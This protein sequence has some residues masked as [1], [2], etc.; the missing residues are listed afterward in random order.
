MRLRLSDRGDSKSAGDTAAHMV[1]GANSS[2]AALSEPTPLV[3]LRASVGPVFEG[4]TFGDH[5]RRSLSVRIRQH[6]SD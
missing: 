4:P 6:T 2:R 5:P 3:S 1:G